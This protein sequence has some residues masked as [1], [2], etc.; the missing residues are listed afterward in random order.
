VID[1]LLVDRP[2]PIFASYDT[3]TLSPSVRQS[4]SFASVNG[5]LPVQVG[6]R[7]VAH[8]VDDDR[9]VRVPR[10]VERH[11]G[12]G[13]FPLELWDVD[14]LSSARSRSPKKTQMSP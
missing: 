2:W 10:E 14:D 3:Y 4:V 13:I 8:V 11:A 7:E 1:E 5:L 12:P 6:V 9:V